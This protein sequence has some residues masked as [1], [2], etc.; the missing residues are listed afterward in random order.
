M[1]ISLRYRSPS[2]EIR[3][4]TLREIVQGRPL[5]HPSHAVP[6]GLVDWAQMVKGSRKRRVATR[7]MLLQ[8]T[9]FGT[10]LIALILRYPHR[11]TPQARASWIAI[12]A[13]GVIVL[14]FG[15]YLGGRLVYGMAMRVSTGREQSD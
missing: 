6:T 10:F 9:T 3:P 5:G 15:Q 11:H 7:R 13:I 1:S 12:E 2:G 14:L 8:F 4:L